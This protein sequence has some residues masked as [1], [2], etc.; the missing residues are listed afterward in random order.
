MFP[1]F[2]GEALVTNG[3][4]NAAQSK[5]LSVKNFLCTQGYY[6]I[7]TIA[8][9]SKDELDEFLIP[10]DAK[11]RKVIEILNPITENL[12][13]MRT[14]MA[15]AMVRAIENNIKNGNTDLRFF[16]LANVY[17]P[18]ELPL[19]QAPDEVKT[20]CLGTSGSEED[21]FTMKET[22]ENFASYNNIKFT[23]KRG[24]VSYL[25]P[26]RTADVYCRWHSDRYIRTVK[27]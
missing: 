19:T 4:L 25:H 10:A 9:T 13:V 24:N 27:I 14:L 7:Q 11:E 20:L 3:G 12:S 22:L 18:K 1:T 2:L 26:G 17:I 8:M 6:E 21:F 16:E 5:E 23:Y 15:P